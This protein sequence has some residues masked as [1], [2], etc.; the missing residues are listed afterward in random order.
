VAD[1]SIV[2]TG[3]PN[4]VTSGSN[5]TYTLT[6]TN[7][8]PATSSSATVTDTLP[9]GVSFVSAS[10][11]CS[12]TT[13]VTC[14]VGS[15]G[16][17]G[18]VVFTIVVKVN[19]APGTVISNTATVAGSSS[20]TDTTTSNNTSTVTTTTGS[21]PAG[22]AG[23]FQPDELIALASHRL[24]KGNDIYNGTG[25]RQ[26][27]RADA[28]HGKSKTALVKIQNDGNQVDTIFLTAQGHR[29]GYS[30]K[31]YHGNTNI[32][33]RIVNRVYSFHLNPGA[34]RL[35]RVVVTVLSRARDNLVRSWQVEARSAS[36]PAKRDV[37]KFK[38]GVLPH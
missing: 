22:P 36:D 21:P 9:G 24:F 8:G 4:P 6:V 30:V 34:T 20:Q 31:Y 15:L 10:A 18:T 32:S 3:S 37:V 12:G 26:T 19:A 38:V 17:G 11:G 16:P 25:G 29:P 13:T 1:L 27:A 35:I 14:T 7:N 2:K 23:N 33:A 28:H 5:L